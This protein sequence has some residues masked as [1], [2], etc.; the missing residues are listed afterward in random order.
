[1]RLRSLCRMAAAGLALSGCALFEPFE[2]SRS[3]GPC[4]FDTAML[5]FAGDALTQARCLLRTFAFDGMGDIE[6]LVHLCEQISD[7]R[8]LAFHG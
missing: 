7:S 6:H 8:F 3:I 1:M 5:Q 2:S 4:G